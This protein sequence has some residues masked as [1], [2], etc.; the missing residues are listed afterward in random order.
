MKTRRIITLVFLS[1]CLVFSAEYKIPIAALS[2]DVNDLDLDGDLDIVVGHWTIWGDT[3][4]TI[5]ILKNKGNGEFTIAD[6]SISFC[7]G[8]DNIQATCIDNDPYPDIIMLMAD[9]SSDTAARFIRIFYNNA[10]NFS[11][12]EDFPL[13]MSYPFSFN[14]SGDI[15]GDGD[16]D[17]ILASHMYYFWGI[18]YNLGDGK[19]SAPTYYDLDY[20]PISL[21]CGDMNNDGRAEIVISGIRIQ[22]YSYA[23]TGFVCEIIEGQ[24]TRIK[25]CDID[26]DGDNDIVGLSYDYF[27]GYS[28]I[29]IYENK[30]NNHFA[31]ESEIYFKPLLNIIEVINMN[32]DN[33]P[34]L[35]CTGDDC[36]YVLVNLGNCQLASPQIFS[37]PN[38][39]QYVCKSACADLDG[40][41]YDDVITI[42]HLYVPVPA[43][44][45]YND[46]H[47]GFC[48]Q[49]VS[50]TISSGKDEFDSFKLFQNYPN[51]F[52]YSTNITYC[53][54]TSSLVN[55]SIYTIRGRLVKSLVN[56]IQP[57]GMY[58][59]TWNGKSNN[60]TFVCSG[61][62]LCVL[63]VND[64]VFTKLS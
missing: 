40:N 37:L 17:I 56:E 21:E 55:L 39:G 53:F 1:I 8:T 22:I 10:G 35:I 2:V 27:T 32:N 20:M 34:D 50:N 41:G 7:G 38:Y 48:D 24:E 33:L 31:K 61:V 42:R 62:Y 45:F 13:Y 64:T 43:N 59:V 25:I 11:V 3:N 9:F 19:F 52:N 57:N 58:T 49:P 29:S 26:H 36:L 46:G 44:I 63:R 4:K 16:I 60:D 5:S 51:P 6:T 30:N 18:L 14:T 12:Y 15:D 54:S 23:D 47:S 28:R